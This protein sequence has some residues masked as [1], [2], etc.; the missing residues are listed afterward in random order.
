MYLDHILPGRERAVVASQ[1][2]GKIRQG[3]DVIAAAQDLK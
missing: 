2:H 1:G 3:C